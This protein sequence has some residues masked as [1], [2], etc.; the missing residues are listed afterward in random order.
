M[1]SAADAFEDTPL[2]REMRRRSEEAAARAFQEAA[3]EGVSE[4]P[5]PPKVKEKRKGPPWSK[6][7]IEDLAHPKIAALPAAA[8]RVWLV[9]RHKV[10]E[11]AH[12][13][14][15]ETVA[16]EARVAP[17][18]AA[19]VIGALVDAGLVTREDRTGRSCTWR[20]LRPA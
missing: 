8:L 18:T 16:R 2:G 10:G 13:V 19:N 3:A 15:L 11:R 9:M 7:F 14:R 12:R 5:P 20:A 6:V 17:G 1:Q 4:E